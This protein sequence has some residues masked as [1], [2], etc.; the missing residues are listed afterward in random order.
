MAKWPFRF[1]WILLCLCPSVFFFVLE[2]AFIHSFTLCPWLPYSHPTRR[3]HPIILSL[4][5]VL[6]TA[7]SV[8][9]RGQNLREEQQRLKLSPAVASFE[10]LDKL[11]ADS[12]SSRVVFN[13][14]SSH[15][16]SISSLIPS[17]EFEC[18]E[19]SGSITG[20]RV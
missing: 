10:C 6:S 5:T 1:I 16:S 20:G 18:W 12:P 7:L 2:N 13:R 15:P 8:P 3:Q 14:S 11:Q 4:I 19:L 17:R 9:C